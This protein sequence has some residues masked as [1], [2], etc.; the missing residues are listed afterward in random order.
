MEFGEIDFSKELKQSLEL[1]DLS[2]VEF[3]LGFAI[4]DMPPMKVAA[5]NDSKNNGARVRIV[6]KKKNGALVFDHEDDLEAW[7]WSG[8]IDG[9]RQFI[10]LR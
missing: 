4:R 5:G 6:L 9:T 2:S 3:I 1:G 8:A 10:Y 7:T